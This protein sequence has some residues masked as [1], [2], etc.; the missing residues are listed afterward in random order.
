M[1]AILTTHPTKESDDAPRL[2]ARFGGTHCCVVDLSRPL[3]R[4]RAGFFVVTGKLERPR[5]ERAVL[6]MAAA[7]DMHA[8]CASLVEWLDYFKSLP[9]VDPTVQQALDA[10][11]DAAGTKARAALAK[12]EG[13]P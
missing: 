13:N 7:G 2:E 11:E 12:A 1:E 9:S 5:Y 3:L 10:C 8:A 6:R 4:P